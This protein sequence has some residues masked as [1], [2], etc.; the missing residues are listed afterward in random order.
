MI[1]KLATGYSFK[2]SPDPSF[3][4]RGIP[5]FVKGREGGILS[6]MPKQ[7]WD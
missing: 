4:K 3:P 1:V 7:L 2:I 5:P 6:A